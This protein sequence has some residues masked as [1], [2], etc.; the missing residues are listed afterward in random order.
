VHTVWLSVWF[1]QFWDTK[2]FA[3]ASILNLTTP[4]SVYILGRRG[5]V[6]NG[7]HFDFWGCTKVL[8]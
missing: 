4:F 2:Q 1:E 3:G 5:A 6:A 7:E 8:F